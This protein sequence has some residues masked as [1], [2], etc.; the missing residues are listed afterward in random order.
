MIAILQ[1]HALLRPY[2][3]PVKDIITSLVIRGYF[4]A[5]NYMIQA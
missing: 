2:I 5:K 1:T 3:Q 4:L